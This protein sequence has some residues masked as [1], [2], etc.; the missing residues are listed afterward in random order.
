[1]SKAKA[2]AIQAKRESCSTAG[3]YPPAGPLKLQGV[4]DT[5]WF[6][7]HAE[8]VAAGA[9]PS[10]AFNPT[11]LPL[12]NGA[13][14]AGAKAYQ[15]WL[16]AVFKW[17]VPLGARP[18]PHNI[19]TGLWEPSPAE[20]AAG[21]PEGF[22]AVTKLL[23]PAACGKGGAGQ[24]AQIWRD[25]WTAMA[26][27]F[28]LAGVTVGAKT[29]VAT[30][31]GDKADCKGANQE[32]FPAG[33]WASVPAYLHASYIVAGGSVVRGALTG[34]C[35]G[36]HTPSKSLIYGRGA[37][38]VCANLN[39]E[40]SATTHRKAAMKVDTDV[41]V[42]AA[43][44]VKTGG[45]AMAVDLKCRLDAAA[46]SVKGAAVTKLGNQRL[47]AR[48]CLV[49]KACETAAGSVPAMLARCPLNA[50]CLRAA[51][52]VPTAK[53]KCYLKTFAKATIEDKKV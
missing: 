26:T 52:G 1:M 35:W 12:T 10:V 29:E 16:S 21:I 46:L 17:M 47:S 43:A 51:K 14:V 25:S 39:K 37:Y 44:A 33:L 23:A 42:A 32:Q 22:G 5:W 45:D 53:A 7:V 34:K 4:L 8:G 11:F 30:S 6:S 41:L 27:T 15:Y 48:A 49:N 38:A 28:K 19:M 50:A 2:K 9:T 18:A 40:T 20:A 36:S 31:G 13:I 3:K 24:E